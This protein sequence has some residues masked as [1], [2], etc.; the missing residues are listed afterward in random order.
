MKHFET[1]RARFERAQ[2][3]CATRECWS[4]FP[5]MPAKYPDSA[6]AQALGLAAFRAHLGGA[7]DK[8][9]VLDQ[10]GRVGEQ[11]EEVSPYTRQKLGIVYPQADP[12]TL[13]DAATRAIGSW[14]GATVDTRIGVLMEV[15][16]QIGRAHV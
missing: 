8:S 12:N 5:D 13:F 7:G 15:V 10:P 6:A 4:P 16:D 2:V 1:H 9:F 3:A 14:S 11:G